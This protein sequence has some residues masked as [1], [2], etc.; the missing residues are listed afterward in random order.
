MTRLSTNT[1]PR[2]CSVEG[3]GRK[4]Y[5][6]GYCNTHYMQL[7]RAGVIKP[8]NLTLADRFWAKVEKA[9]DAGCWEWT[10]TKPN[11]YGYIKFEGR[12][13]QATHV[14][15]YLTYGQWPPEGLSVCHACDT[16]SCVNPQHLF[17]A[18]HAINMRDMALKGRAKPSRL[19]GEANPAAKLD[20]RTVRRIRERYAQ[21]ES[22]AALA[23]EYSLHREYVGKI[24][25]RQAWAHV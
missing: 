7:R 3:C 21:G 22:Q 9:D 17:L 5:G 13:R 6:R 10:G 25:R 14:V 1:S 19:K 8:R 4:H 18:P 15:W 16:P 12:D 2:A 20:K 23:R 11:G 24:V